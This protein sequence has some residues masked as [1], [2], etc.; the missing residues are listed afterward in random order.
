MVSFIW[1]I[2]NSTEGQRKGGKTEWEVREKN[3][4]RL[5]T[6]GNNPQVV[7]GEV[8]EGMG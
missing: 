6:L 4:E 2:R 1:N 8:G 7:G 3:H 5:L